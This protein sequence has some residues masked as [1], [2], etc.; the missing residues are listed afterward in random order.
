MVNQKWTEHHHRKK[1]QRLK[2]NPKKMQTGAKGKL[3]RR[4]PARNT[5]VKNL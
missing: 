4:R 3:T 2:E 1:S 5:F